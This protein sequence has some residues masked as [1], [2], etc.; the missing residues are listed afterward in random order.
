MPL[1]EYECSEHGGFDEQRP[2]SLASA[3]AP[4]PHCGA[5]A[6]RVL[7][8]P[9]VAFLARSE[10]RARDINERN[11]HEP[12]LVQR[13]PVRAQEPPPRRVHASHGRPW[14]IGH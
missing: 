8:A 12:R 3:A 4:C 2:M 13:E 11:Q 14:A 5:D 9:N 10:R 1:Y 6:R 7:S